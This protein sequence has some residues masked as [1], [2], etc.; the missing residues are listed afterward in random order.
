VPGLLAQPGARLI[1][2]TS[3][4]TPAEDA[5]LDRLQTK[6]RADFLAAGRSHLADY[7]DQPLFG[8]IVRNVP[9]LDRAAAI[10]V[11][12]LN[13][14]VARHGGCRCAIVAVPVR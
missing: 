11:S 8:V 13:Q 10:R 14:R 7:L 1:T 3:P 4:L 5:E 6:L 9:G 2:S 12:Q